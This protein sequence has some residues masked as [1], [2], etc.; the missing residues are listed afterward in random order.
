MTSSRYFGGKVVPDAAQM[1]DIFNC[2]AANRY[3]REARSLRRDMEKAGHLASGE[4]PVED[5]DSIM[6][7]FP[8]EDAEME[9][10]QRTV[11]SVYGNPYFTD[12]VEETQRKSQAVLEQEKHL[13]NKGSA[14]SEVETEESERQQ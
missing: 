3:F 4:I 13:Q 10:R 9:T 14:E 11:E 5:I 2:L 7:R 8:P 1:C 6:T 12:D